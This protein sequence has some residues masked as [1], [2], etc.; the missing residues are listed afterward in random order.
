MRTHSDSNAIKEKKIKENKIIQEHVDFSKIDGEENFWENP[1]GAETEDTREPSEH[2]ETSKPETSPVTSEPVPD[3]LD[4][5]VFY[6]I[7]PR[8]EDKKK[9]EISWKNLTKKDQ[10]SALDAI[11][12]HIAKWKQEGRDR[13]KI[14]LPTS[15]LHGRRWEDILEDVSHAEAKKREQEEIKKKR[16]E[17]KKRE[18]EYRD[19]EK[20]LAKYWHTLDPDEQAELE[21]KA[22]EITAK[23]ISE[24]NLGFDQMKKTRLRSILAEKYYQIQPQ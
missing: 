15:W 12:R 11:P 2:P 18:Q 14:P 24:R 19:Q 13:T 5:S 10:K 21:E 1:K 6:A 3:P 4:F 16:A 9:A 7:F 23:I 17:A 8:K 22:H 20:E